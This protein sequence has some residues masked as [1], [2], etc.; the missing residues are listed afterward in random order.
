MS[1]RSTSLRRKNVYERIEDTKRRISETEETLA[2][3]KMLLSNQMAE[4]DDLEMHQLFDFIRKN[5]ISLD[6]AKDLMSK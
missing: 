2:Q 5:N 6:Q 4:R 3:L 1:S